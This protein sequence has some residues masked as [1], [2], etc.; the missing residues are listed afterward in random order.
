MAK[1]AVY[2][3]SRQSVGEIELP[4]EV[5]GTDVN[6]GL[7]YDVL[8]AQLASKRAGT[9]SSKNR[10]EVR[11]STKK[12]Y[13]QKGTGRARHGSIT[14]P[15]FVGGGKAHGPVPRDYSYRPPR[16]MRMGALKS[17]LSL[18]LKEGR[19]I[20]LE[21]FALS[22]IK[23]K[24]LAQILSTLEVGKS[25]II[26]DEKTNQNLRMSVQNLRTHQFLPPEGVNLYDLLRHEHLVVT[27]SAV[28]ALSARCRA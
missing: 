21:D 25:S 5:F 18:K 22:E 9:H 8:K 17:A 23:T 19:L 6:E 27:K 1:V 20:V 10:S 7:L 28:E 13:R 14:S 12:L 16:K 24:K 15:V 2:N 3:L 4:D 11:G 26:V